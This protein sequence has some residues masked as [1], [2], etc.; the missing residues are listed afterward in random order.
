MGFKSE[1]WS[2]NLNW[3]SILEFT[4]GIFQ[5]THFVDTDDEIQFPYR[6][7]GGVLKYILKTNRQASK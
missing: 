2:S 5:G 7:C 6:I 1:N 3:G 4:W